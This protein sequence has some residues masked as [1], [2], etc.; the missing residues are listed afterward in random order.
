MHN[1]GPAELAMGAQIVRRILVEF[2]Q[3]LK[4]L[5]DTAGNNIVFVETQGTLSPVDWANELH[6]NPAGFQK[7]AQKFVG[8]LA[9]KFPGR[10]AQQAL[11]AAGPT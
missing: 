9:G 6:P 2:H 5:A 11:A 1:T 3:L 4:K 8:P 7:I 10:A